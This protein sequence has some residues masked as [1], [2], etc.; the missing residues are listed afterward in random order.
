MGW[1]V[2]DVA[3]RDDRFKKSRRDA[4]MVEEM[5]SLETESCKDDLMVEP[6]GTTH[7]TFCTYETKF[8]ILIC[9]KYTVPNG[10]GSTF[11]FTIADKRPIDIIVEIPDTARYSLKV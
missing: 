9:C 7:H 1:G 4:L 3:L 6:V 10:T 5:V 11:V 8:S 2:G